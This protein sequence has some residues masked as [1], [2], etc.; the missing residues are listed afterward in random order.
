[1]L[2][3]QLITDILN[4]QSNNWNVIAYLLIIGKIYVYFHSTKVE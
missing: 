1:M 4:F 2:H 3:K